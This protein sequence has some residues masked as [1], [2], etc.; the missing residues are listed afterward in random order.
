MWEWCH[1]T[2][3]HGPL[4]NC[5]RHLKN[6]CCITNVVY[7]GMH[8][9]VFGR[10]RWHSTV[11]PLIEC[12]WSG[13]AGVSPLSDR[14][15]WMDRSIAALLEPCC[16][17]LS[18]TAHIYGTCCLWSLCV[19]CYV[20]FLSRPRS[21]GWPHHG[22]TFGSRPSDHY[23]RSVC[24]FVCLSVCLFVCLFVQSFSQLSLIQFRS[25]LDIGLCYMS[26]SSCV[27]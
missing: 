11:L 27:T 21:E 10:G 9:W 25:N 19:F 16:H 3:H 17:A 24:W 13:D 12:I 8:T 26:G 23:F 5:Q 18:R 6:M 1:M 7:D 20:L 4:S 14:S 15:R 2:R 22:R